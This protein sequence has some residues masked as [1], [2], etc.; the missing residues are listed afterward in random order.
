MRN[1]E[2]LRHRRPPDRSIASAH[3]RREMGIIPCPE[4]PCMQKGILQNECNEVPS[5]ANDVLIESDTYDLRLSDGPD[6]TYQSEPS[7]L[8]ES[9][10]TGIEMR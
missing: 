8:I 4:S 7:S 10:W 5:K 9:R 6:Q 3:K 1:R 2:K